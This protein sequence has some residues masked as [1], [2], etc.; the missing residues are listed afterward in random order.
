[1]SGSLRHGEAIIGRHY[2]ALD[3]YRFAAACGVVLFHFAH[4]WQDATPDSAPVWVGK[5]Y[6]FVDFFFMISGFVIAEGY[7][8]RVGGPAHILRFLQRRLARI[9]PLHLLTLVFYVGVGL[10]LTASGHVFGKP[11]SFD[12]RTVPDHLLLMHA[13]GTVGALSFNGASWSISAEF[14]AYLLFPAFVLLQR[15]IGDVGLVALSV[16][17]IVGLTIWRDAAGLRPWTQATFDYGALRALP[18]FLLGMAASGLLAG[19][20][21]RLRPSWP[22]AHIAFVL[23]PTAMVL[24]APDLVV[25]ALGLLAVVLVVLAERANEP[26]NGAAT[27]VMLGNLSYGIYMLHPIAELLAIVAPLRLYPGLAPWTGALATLA[28][29]FTLLAAAVVFRWFEAPARRWIA[30]LGESTEARDGATT[31]APARAARTSGS[32]PSRSSA[33]R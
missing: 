2:V 13:W 33:V 21:R 17:L 1:M 5:F 19:W 7:R 16:M 23:V 14:L 12:L 28:A 26:P 10:L 30:G 3:A 25:I 9:Y 24:Q 11:E 32:F 22:V 29:L 8:D 18:T 15:R 6:L 20:S 4:H 31:A 27:L